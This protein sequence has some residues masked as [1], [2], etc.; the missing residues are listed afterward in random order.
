MTAPVSSLPTSEQGYT[1]SSTGAA[2][3]DAAA[4][5][6]TPELRWPGSVRVFEAMSD[7]D[8][9][10]ASVLRAIMLPVL[11]TPWRVEPNGARDE[12]VA[13]IAEDLRLPI[14]GG[15]EQ[16]PGRARGRFSWQKHLAEAMLMVRYGH[17]YFEQEVRIDDRGRARLAHLRSRPART[18]SAITVAP[19]GGLVSIE[20][21][22]RPQLPGQRHVQEK[23][24][25][26][27]RLV[28]YIHQQ[29]AGDWVGRSLLRPA[30][31]NWLIKDRLLRVQAQT[32]ERN[33]MGVPI[34]EAGPDE[35]DYSKGEE[36]ARSY[37]SGENA[38][39]ATPPGG[40]LRLVG[41]EGD[42]PDANPA[43]RYHDEQIA[44]AAL[45]H[46]LNLG[47][48]TGSW[49]LGTTF[50]DFFVMSLQTFADTVQEVAN[51]H[52]VEDL[53]D[54]NWGPD[55]PA[56]LVVPD[57]IGG[58]QAALVQAIKLLVDSGILRPDRDLEEFMRQGLGLPPKATPPADPSDGGS[59][60]AARAALSRPG[61][62]RGRPIS[63]GG[64]FLP[65]MEDL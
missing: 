22:A 60:A 35:K 5:E 62:R 33:G 51:Q 27:S 32:I 28:A 59:A 38:G 53:V 40:K 10:V 37:R 48:Q 56:P 16:V 3:W 39:G 9:Q 34:Y 57:E 58:Q 25:P 15:S 42:L 7:Q 14:V 11:R 45:A 30:Y 41:V 8:S 13:Q 63:P 4:R 65:G 46:A 6:Q 20:Q 61:A 44:R 64:L 29:E 23:P 49:A 47:T 12:V 43:I 54:W 31:K 17:A 18:L 19:D 1:S 21:H 24:I 55:E 50:M 52:I 2:W 36:L 26:V